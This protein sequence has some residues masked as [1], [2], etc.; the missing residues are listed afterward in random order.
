MKDKFYGKGLSRSILVSLLVLFS[1]SGVS[2][3]SGI[4]E[5]YAVLDVNGSNT[6]YDLQATTANPDFQ[7]ANLGSF[8]SA[9]SLV[10]NGAQ[11]KTFKCAPCDITNGNFYWRVWLTSAGASGAFTNINLPFGSNLGSGCGGNDQIW[12]GLSGTTNIISGLTTPGNYTLEVYTSADYQGC[13]TGTN[14]SNNGGAN[15]KATFTYCG[16][17][18]GAL[19]AGNYSIPGCFPTVASAITY[20]NTNGVTG[21]GTVQF[22]IAA[23]YTETAPAGGFAITATGTSTLGIAFVK[24]GT[25]ANPSFKANGVQSVGSLNDAVFKIVGGDYI[26]IDGFTIQ[27]NSLNTTSSPVS[28]N[29]MTEFGVAL[30]YASTTNGS[31]NNTI[32]NC[33][34]S[35]NRTYL[36]TFGIYSNT[37]HSATAVSTAAEVTSAAGTNS[38]NKVYANAISNV[39]YGIVFIGSGA[40]TAV[41]DSGNDV[42]G[43]S[44][45]T[46]NTLTNC[47]GGG[48]V[49]TYQAL[50]GNN[51]MIFFNQQ[52]NGN[53]SYNSITSA[54]VSTTVTLGGILQNYSIGQPTGMTTSTTMT[55]NT[56]TLTNTGTGTVI[57]VNNQGISTALSTASVTMSNNTVVSCSLT[58]GAGQ[59]FTGVTNIS[60]VGTLNMTGNV[61]RNISTASTSGS[62]TGVSNSAAVTNTIN[63][64]NNQ[65]G[66]AT[67]GAV[68]Y[69]A[70]TSAAFLGITNTGGAATAALTITGND[71][72]GIVY[73]VASSASNTYISNSAATFSQNISFNTFTNLN[74]NTTGSATFITNSVTL[75]AGGSKTINNN[76]IVTAFNKGGAGGTITLYSDGASSP[77]GT[78]VNN[79]SNNF[80]NITVTG[81]TTVSGWTNND[82]V[83]SGASNTKTVMNNTF[84]NWTGG[85]S[86]VTA[87]TVGASGTGTVTGNTIGPITSAGTITGLAIGSNTQDAYGNTI[88][89]LTTTGALTVTGLFITSGVANNIFRNKIGNLEANNANGSVVGISGNSSTASSVITIHN[90]LIGD[91]RAPIAGNASSINGISLTAGAA[92]LTYNLY[93]NTVYLSGTSTGANFG[94]NALSVSTTPVVLL[95]NN[96]FVNAMTSTGTG[97]SAAYRRSSTGLTTYSTS[98]NNNDFFGAVIFADGA[99]TDTTLP[100]F[101]SR[102]ANRD[103]ASVTE[104][105]SFLSTS[106][107]SSNFLHLNTAVATQLESTGSPIPSFTTDYDSDTRNAS[108]PDI[109]ADEFTG[110]VSDITGPLIIYTALTNTACLVTAPT[111]S[112][113]ITDL[114]GVNTT[115]GTKPRLYYKKSTTANAFVGNTSS[116]LGWKYVEANN[117]SS[118]FTFTLNYAILD[119]AALAPGDVIQYFVVAQDLGTTPNVSLNSGTFNAN[120]ASVALTAAAAPIG[121]TINSYTVVAPGLSGT[122]TIGASGTY[123]SLTGTSGLFNAINTSGLS[124]N[125]TVNIIDSSIA[126]TGAVALNAIATIGCAAGPYTLTIKP[127]SGVTTTLSG[128]AVGALIKLNGADNVIIDGSNNGSTSRNMT[129][130]NTGTTG[131]TTAVA[132]VSLGTGLG[133]TNNTVKNCNLSTGVSTITAS[134]GI[135]VGGNSPGTSGADNDSVTI[136]NNNIS[137]ASIGIYANGT[138][139]SA[140]GGNDNLSITNNIVDYNGSLSCIGIQVGN[141][142][143]SVVS[144]NAV[145]EQ[146]NVT[147]APVGISLETGFVSSSVTRNSITK[148]LAANTNGYGGR[149]ITIATGTAASNLTIA[150]NFISGVGGSNWNSFSNS[151]SIGIGIGV[152]GTS[153]TVSSTTGGVNLYYNT[154]VMDGSMG[155][156]S[157]TALTTALYVG[158]GASS[159]DI[160][161]NILVNTMTGTNAGQKNYAL[162]SVAANT[163]YTNINYNNYYVSNS[164]NAG[165]A[166]MGFIGSDR[167]NL[168][169]MVSGFGQN[170][171]SVNLLPVF[172]SASDLHLV[173]ASNTLLNDLGTPVA[174]TTDYDGTARSGSAPDMGAD[175]FT[176]PCTTVVGGTASGTASFCASGTP[177]ITATGYS[178]GTGATYQ[179]MSSTVAADYPNAGTAVSGQTN[180]ATLT[181]G[182]VST[183]TYYWLRVTCAT[184]SSTDNS[185]LVT[186]TVSPA[187][188]AGTVS[189]DQTICAGTTPADLTLSGQVG[190]VVKWQSSSDAA[191]TSPA[192][193]TNA[194]MTLTGTAIGTLTSDTWFRAVVKSGVCSTLF[195]SAIKITVTPLQTFYTDADN[196]GYGVT[197]S[198]VLA[199]S[200]PANTTTIG[201]DC[202]DANAAINPGATEIYGDGIDNNC[203]GTIDTDAAP[204]SAVSHYTG[205]GWDFPPVATQGVAF[206]H[207]YTAT[208]DLAACSLTVSTGVNVVVGTEDPMTHAMTSA[209]D[210]DI[211]GPVVVNG[212][213][214]LTFEQ[215]SNLLQTG[216]TSDTGNQGNIIVKAKV[217][218]WRQDYVYWGS[219]V[220]SQ[221]LYA[222]SP[223]TLW[224]RFYTF[225]PALNAYATVFSASTDPAMATYDFSPG[226][227]YMVRAPNT[228]P[229]PTS[230][231]ATP[232]TW[233]LSSFTGTPKNG[234]VLVTTTNGASNVHMLANPYPSTIDAAAFRAANGNGALY[235]W[236]HHDQVVGSNNYASITNLGAAAAYAGGVVPNGTIQV[237]QGFLLANTGNVSSA[238]FTN[239]M[240]VGNN[241]GQFFRTADAD[242]SRIWLNVA[243]NGIQGNQMLVGYT[244]NTTL[245]DDNGF[246]AKLIPSGNNISSMIGSD[247]YVIQARPAFTAEDVVPMGLHAETAGTYTVSLDHAD[248]VFEG[249]QDIFLKDNLTGAVTNLKQES[250][251]FVTEVGDFNDRLQLQY[252]NTTLAN[253]DFDTNSV[254]IYK[255]DNRVLTLSAGTLEIKTVKIFDVRGRLVYTKDAISSNIAQLGDLKAE[256][257]VLLLQVTLTDGKVVIRKVAY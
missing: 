139:S 34:I 74:L 22:D 163:A 103:N 119:G 216:Y 94:S 156:A 178:A 117:G 176:P 5:S 152:L 158:S 251:S 85:T 206:D 219:P 49:S 69:S 256:A 84:S 28:S 198:T 146:N 126:E 123:T 172:T 32:K 1:I 17:A 236:T 157:T 149:G 2:A 92:T 166:I 16:P 61:I 53:I 246:E 3:Q 215:G 162:Y 191:F 13:G 129:I 54:S 14:Y 227:G 234:S 42:G 202:D 24:S 175:E 245:D 168:A 194:T 184:N 38:N 225:N 134:Y 10:V 151:S 142:L 220:K 205:T 93:Y 29:N 204:C 6:F 132:L 96:A 217:K 228:F 130:A 86:S 232:T 174:V 63:I 135:S 78:T 179:W 81:A 240:R 147:S 97:V 254:F 102:V 257:Q 60:A 153:T 48:A 181:T 46:G 116:D 113:T 91:L 118:P 200:A 136:Q 222:F 128:S 199:C 164:F 209:Y 237:G 114:S 65:I 99:N 170:A 4:F 100:A 221:K 195:S 213:G 19:P 124:D 77:S 73:S 98:S 36:N 249:A 138:A 21:T 193:I 189:A 50:T 33:T 83:S 211:S 43:S 159:L 31:Q 212:T 56:V 171:N 185:T 243:N 231:G 187:T 125:L 122:V 242:R 244:A 150:N 154:V 111:L 8:N 115:A 173:P 143:N 59:S 203:N 233:F 41:I 255:D 106:V 180:P 82:G 190:S 144:Q 7:G 51:Y 79:N 177:T 35:L 145:T 110:I 89:G 121:G 161:N 239:A 223:L 207:D 27:E 250:Y 230:S 167:T 101:K 70:A 169:G 214:T 186:I 112:A 226:T 52:N 182:V 66:N 71:F 183:T 68:T 109:G 120:P 201:G 25:G 252:V 47:G 131:G 248:G 224:N 26:T 104:N 210:F 241:A 55:N 247:R 45:A 192:D 141:A 165:S 238:S 62:F 9:G 127:D 90:N 160:R 12:Q 105:P 20:I 58:G 87:L 18:S 80:S 88:S 40:S 155:T 76:S 57:G 75:P 197:S 30:L 188:V 107:S 23:G 39:N 133:A 218:E 44:A 67:G 72:R 11:N 253:P 15:Y 64:T 140:S 235:F 208:S 148:S 108:T 37:R 95:R 229:N 196:D 137:G